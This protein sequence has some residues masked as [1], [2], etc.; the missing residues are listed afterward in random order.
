MLLF[1]KKREDK[2]V[3]LY[4]VSQF[5]MVLLTLSAALASNSLVPEHWVI[6]SAMNI[7][8][9]AIS[10]ATAYHFSNVFLRNI[11]IFATKTLLVIYLV[12]LIY[13]SLYLIDY[14]IFYLEVIVSEYSQFG[15][16]A[17][18]GTPFS[19]L[20]ILFFYLYLG[21]MTILTALNYFRMFRQKFNLELRRRA[22]YFVLS[23]LIPVI[24]LT[25]TIF[26]ALVVPNYHPKLELTIVSLS[27]SG[28]I[29]AY[30]ILKEKLFDIDLIVSKSVKYTLMNI[31]LAWI[32]VISREIMTPLISEL[33]FSGS[34]VATLMAGFF[35]VTFSIPIKYIASNFTDKLFPKLGRVQAPALEFYRDQLELA[36]SDRNITEKEQMMLE[37][38]RF[39]LDISNEN[40]D[41]LERELFS[42]RDN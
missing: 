7:V 21:M 29:V 20:L 17:N 10:V 2:H 9:S 30:G 36:Y 26:L 15:I 1:A 18:I 4:I 19:S 6:W 16:Y 42:Q 33:L 31:G 35:V 34:Q 40:H 3:Q 8:T 24:T 5:F 41:Q 22:A 28:S 27:L 38:L 14:R 11:P 37:A 13:L 32:F 39:Y 23:T 12:P 25:I